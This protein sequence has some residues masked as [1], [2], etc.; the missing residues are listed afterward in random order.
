MASQRLRILIVEDEMLV[1]MNIEDMLLDLGHEVAGLASRLEPA[2]S[3]AR[4]AEFDLA[5]LDVNLA[6]QSSF[7][8]AEILD[9]RGIPFL[10][11]TGYGIKGIIEEFR[12][13][14]VL[15]KPFRPGDLAQA[16]EAAQGACGRGEVG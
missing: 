5:M 1:A 3:L 4:E 13:C 7:P 2:L 15:Q 6:G 16:I 14:V 12:S 8:V 11:A 9:E 10:F